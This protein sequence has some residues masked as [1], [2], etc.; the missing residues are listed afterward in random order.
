[1]MRPFGLRLTASSGP[2]ECSHVTRSAGTSP[3]PLDD[4][5]AQYEA[6]TAREREVMGYVTAGLMNKRWLA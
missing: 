5:R 4:L 2:S 6:L 1:M 3:R